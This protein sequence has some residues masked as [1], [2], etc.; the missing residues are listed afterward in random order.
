MKLYSRLERQYYIHDIHWLELSA[1]SG[2]DIIF[3]PSEIKD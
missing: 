1:W 3:L 2:S